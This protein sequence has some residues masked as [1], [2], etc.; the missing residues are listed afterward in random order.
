MKSKKDIILVV[1]SVILVFVLI[2]GFI[3]DRNEALLD[4]TNRFAVSADDNLEIVKV[5]K[6]GFLYARAYYEAKLH[7][8]NSNY[9]TWSQY[10]LRIAQTYGGEGQLFDYAQYKQYEADCLDTASLKPEPREDSLVWVLGV[11]L[12]ATTSENMVYILSVEGD[13]AQV[14]IYMYYSRK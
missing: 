7:V 13:D 9:D 14:Y 6:V 11:P 3:Y 8:K 5:N 10:L 1:I 2:G 12:S 4:R